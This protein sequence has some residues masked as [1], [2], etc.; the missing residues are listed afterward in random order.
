MSGKLVL[1]KLGGSLITV[2]DQPHTP[3]LDVIERLAREIAAART[4]N[5]DLQI[6]LGHGSGSYGHVPASEYHTRLGVKTAEEWHGFVEVERQAVELNHLVMDSLG[7]AGLPALSFP[8]L[9]AV[10][11]CEGKVVAWD[12][13]PLKNALVNRLVPVIYGDVVFD[14]LLGGT[15]LSTE[16]LFAHLTS[17]LHP[18]R[19]NFAG[20]EPGVW[21]NFPV[22]TQ[23]LEEITPSS[24][25]QIKAGL[26]GSAA[27]DVTGGML[28]KVR[29]VLSMVTQ[30][31][32]LSASIFSGE[33]DGN[34]R[35]SLAGE[36]LGTVIHDDVD[37]NPPRGEAL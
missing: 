5:P 20:M 29:Q 31:P 9:A 3:R 8:P 23:L 19:L 35:R 34:V 1:L 32:G 16:D 21:H 10:T 37:E 15:I 22:C 30:V 28:D 13:E 36:N 2:K 17:K 27:T 12:L 24:Y 33:I 26:K 7:K 6:L 18:N 14:Q 11:A 25:T 4:L